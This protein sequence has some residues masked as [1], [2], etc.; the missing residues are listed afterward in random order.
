MTSDPTYSPAGPGT[1]A[2][3]PKKHWG[4]WV[5]LG[6]G[7][8]LLLVGALAGLLFFIVRQ[9][10]AGP[11]EVVQE[12]LAAAGA[13]DFA[14]AHDCFSAPLKQVQPLEEFSQRAAANSLF[15]QVTDTTFNS[16]SVDTTGAELSGTVTLESGTEVPASFRLVKE[17]DAWKLISYQI[18]S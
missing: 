7:A 4:R 18:G 14:T 3:S 17:N 16:R 8:A 2:A 15:F 11:E 1:A 9:A 6:C 5:A 10:T 12:F 13:G